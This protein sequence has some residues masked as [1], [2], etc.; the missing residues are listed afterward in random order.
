MKLFGT[1]FIALC[2]LLVVGQLQ[3]Q[4]SK[5]TNQTQ[6]GTTLSTEISFDYDST[7]PTKLSFDI[8]STKKKVWLGVSLYPSTVKDALRE[9]EHQQLELNGE[10]S[11]KVVKVGKKYSGGSFEAALWG[12]KVMQNECTIEDCYWCGKSGFHLDGLLAYKAGAFVCSH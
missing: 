12:R 5:S 8:K 2:L 9:G 1:L 7:I 3:T 11:D 10:T 4:E 6:N